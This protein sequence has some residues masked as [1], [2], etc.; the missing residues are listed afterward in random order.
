MKSGK[1]SYYK[2]KYERI[3]KRYDKKRAIIAIARMILAAIYQR[4]S[5]GEICNPT[6][7]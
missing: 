3:M 6:D 5:T 2:Q 7:L 4:L 1:S